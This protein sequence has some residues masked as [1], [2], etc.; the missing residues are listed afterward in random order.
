MIP[1]A[2]SIDDDPC[3]IEIINRL[4]GHAI[5]QSRPMDVFLT[6]IDHWFGF[7]W[8]AFA[9]NVY[10]QL[11][12]HKS[13]LTIPPFIP[14]RVVSQHAF[15]LHEGGSYRTKRAAP[16]HRH[17]HSGLNLSRFIGNVSE[18]GVFIWFSG[19]TTITGHGS[20]MIYTICGETQ[21]GWYASFRREKDWQ[22]YKVRGL[23]KTELAGMI[24][25]EAAV[26]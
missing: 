16:L 26:S 25:S 5:R 7:K 10:G 23:S 22:L 12:F 8:F 15:R 20:V 11:S 13:R 18:S 24:E 4:V 2:L 1:I 19:D 21:H 17:Q 6:R 14:N 9:G 3:F